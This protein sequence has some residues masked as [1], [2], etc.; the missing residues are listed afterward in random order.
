[1]PGFHIANAAVCFPKH[2]N[3]PPSSATQG[4]SGSLDHLAMADTE[5]K[6]IVMQLVESNKITLNNQVLTDQ[7]K[8]ATDAYKVLVQTISTSRT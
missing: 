5:H 6:E 3:N 7:I 4:I 8:I 2:I 1:M